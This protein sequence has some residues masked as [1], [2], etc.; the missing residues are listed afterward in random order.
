MKEAV[1]QLPPNNWQ[2]VHHIF[3]QRTGRQD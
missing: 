1:E 3:H 2:K